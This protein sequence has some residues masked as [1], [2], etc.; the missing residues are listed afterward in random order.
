MID[1][2]SRNRL[3]Q[4]EAGAIVATG[5]VSIPTPDKVIGDH[6]LTAS[7]HIR[8][9]GQPTLT[10]AASAFT[11][12]ASV[13]PATA[14][15]NY[16]PIYLECINSSSNWRFAIGFR[17]TGALFA[18]GRLTNDSQALQEWRTTWTGSVGN[19]Y[20]IACTADYSNHT[21][22]MFVGGEE[23]SQAASGSWTGTEWPNTDSSA[24]GQGG[25][26]GSSVE[27]FQGRINWGKI[28]NE[29]LTDAQIA[30]VAA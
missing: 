20:I 27:W 26:P 3:A 2:L 11:I 14:F 1:I 30:A 15:I 23:K 4:F 7:S 13:T 18:G 8:S 9:L 21:V 5:G 17:N 19:T 29:L 28:W 10:K 22:R 12:V 16:G 6:T 24:I 25:T